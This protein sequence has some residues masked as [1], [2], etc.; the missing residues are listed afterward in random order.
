[1]AATIADMRKYALPVLLFG[2]LGA[3][4][5]VLV[6]MRDQPV[7][8]KRTGSAPEAR[9]EEDPAPA[10]GG[11]A[12]R[13]PTRT[14][15]EE[16]VWMSE[17]ERAMKRKDLSNARHFQAKICEEID[18]IA[19]DESLAKKLLEDIREFGLESDD[20]ARRD[21]MLQ[22]L[23][24]FEHPDATR[25]IEQ[26]YYKAR[27]PEESMM[28][29]EAMSHDYHDPKRA[30]VWAIEKALTSDNEE[31]RMFAFQVMNE[32][33]NDPEIAVQTGIA[34]YEG[35]TSRK[36]QVRIVEKISVRGRYVPAAAE[37]MRKRLRDPRP[38]EILYIT[39]GIAAWGT[40]KDAA[41]LETLAEEFPAIGDQLR[42]QAEQIRIVRKIEANPHETIPP[43]GPRKG[44][45]KPADPENPPGEGAKEQPGG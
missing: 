18:K 44:T 42:E 2:A 13:E 16:N 23:R 5:F 30:S 35:S 9:A 11:L 43:T 29:L 32:F 25:M 3:V 37:W 26:E 24:V 15:L 12:K 4:V 31:H 34:I 41:Y 7:K 28:L 22:M 20:P 1:M 27:S 8:P 19:A 38:D 45:P 14:S 39:G 6:R 36:E 21:I 33:S 40:E 10:K 17:L